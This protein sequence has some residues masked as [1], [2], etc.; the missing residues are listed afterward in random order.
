MPRNGYKVFSTG[1]IAGMII[2]NRLIRSA[3]YEGGMTV[4]G[5][6]TRNI[7]DLYRNLARGGAGLIITGHMA[8]MPG[9]KGNER[10]LCVF[11]DSYTTE[12]ARIAEV[13]HRYGSDCRIVA[14]ISHVGRQVLHDAKSAAC[15][16]P[17]DVPS[18]VLKKR[19]SVLSER[20]IRIIIARYIDAAARVREAGYDAVEIH[21]AHGYLLSSFLSPY[22][23]RRSDR[24]G[25]STGKRLTILKEIIFGIRERIGEFPVIVKLNC[26]DHVEG[27]I[28]INSFPEIASMVEALGADAIEVSGGMWDCL[29]R[30][31]EELGFFPLPIPE[32]RTRIGS[33]DRQSYYVKYARRLDLGIPVIVD[34]GHRNIDS[35]EEIIGKENIAFFALCR[36]LISEPD[37]PR[38][39][40]EG[41]GSEKANCVSCN[42]CLLE[43]KKGAVRCVLK[44][45][46]L[47]HK[48]VMNLVPRVWKTIFK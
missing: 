33:P 12:I 10:Q 25:G 24:Y 13:V 39:W 47:K 21:C 3:T 6:V 31:E 16:G 20:D 40:L 42:S 36:P 32:A 44:Q 23:N 48:V 11:D 15:V 35:M 1:T 30:T 5:R 2:K 34:G 4:D 28:S 38:R 29:A 8:V 22:T 26:D 7:L 45:N 17:S 18:P 46:R 41:T 9:G 19:A 37:L 43:I 14:Q 27:G